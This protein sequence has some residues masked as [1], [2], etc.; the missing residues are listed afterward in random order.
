MHGDVG[1][2]LHDDGAGL[3]GVDGLEP[4]GGGQV[5]HG[6]AG[7]DCGGHVGVQRQPDPGGAPLVHVVVQQARV[8]ADR[9]AQP[10]GAEVRLDRRGV[11]PVGQPVAEMG[12]ELDEHHRRVGRAAVRPARDQRGQP[13]QQAYAER[14]GITGEVVQDRRRPARRPDVVGD[15]AVQVRRAVDGEG[16]RDPAQGQVEVLRRAG[17]AGAEQLQQVGR[18]V[19]A[20]ARAHGDDPGA[21]GRGG[22]QRAGH[23]PAVR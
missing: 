17:A 14:R 16:E 20:R 15:H 9:G 6:G 3:R 23:E 19:A 10:G 21:G 4:G 22:R 5:A 1:A 11:L 2:G 7:G 12:E 13:V 18:P 8:P